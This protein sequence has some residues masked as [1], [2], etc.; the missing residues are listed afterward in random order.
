MSS[1][2]K[3]IR[4]IKHE[5][6]YRQRRVCDDDVVDERRRIKCLIKMTK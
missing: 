3:I 1:K 6:Y 2:R 4:R 5:N